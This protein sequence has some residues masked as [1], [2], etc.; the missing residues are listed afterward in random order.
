MNHRVRHKL[1]ASVFV[2][3]LKGPDILLLRRKGTGWVDGAFSIPAGGLDAGETISA[4]A[5]REAEEEVGVQIE[6]AHLTYAH[7][8]HSLTE[9]RD[10]VGHFFIVTDWA[11]T[12][13]LREP[14]KHSDLVWWPLRS[15]PPETIP[16]VRQALLC[17][18]QRQPYSEFGWTEP[19]AS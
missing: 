10:W 2:V 16:Y 17:I 5:I 3:L 11:G 1:S 14:E 6:P 15:L 18:D 9:G 12:P 19:P 7:T 13:E 4:A 8:L